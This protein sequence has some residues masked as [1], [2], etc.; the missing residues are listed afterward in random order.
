MLNVFN[1]F[2][3]LLFPSGLSLSLLACS[4][5]LASHS[6][7]SYYLSYVFFLNY[8]R[9]HKELRKLTQKPNV[10]TA[11]ISDLTSGFVHSWALLVSQ[12]SALPQALPQSF[13][14]CGGAWWAVS[15]G[16]SCCHGDTKPD[17]GWGVWGVLFHSF[18]RSK[19]V[20]DWKAAQISERQTKKKKKRQLR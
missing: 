11:M 10:S 1:L 4:V 9:L 19:A 8:T 16:S 2:S 6:A 3:A 14:E 5:S 12:S 7:P 18:F 15:G 13:L 20:R 17:T